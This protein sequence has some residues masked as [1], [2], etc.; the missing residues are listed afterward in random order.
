[1]LAV[2]G[3][4]ITIAVYG[5]VAIIVKAD[6]VGLALARVGGPFGAPARLFGRFLVRFMPWFL[7]LL[8]TVGTAAMIW[9]GGGI[10]L[11]GLEAYGWSWPS[12]RLHDAGAA[13][14]RSIPAIGA[15]LSWLIQAAGAGLIGLCIGLPAIPIMSSFLSPLWRTLKARFR[16]WRGTA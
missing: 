1:V 8:G 10:L 16:R 3:I 2:V 15:F 12:H 6:D 13:A 5:V 14:A 4:A 7:R 9:V 11:H